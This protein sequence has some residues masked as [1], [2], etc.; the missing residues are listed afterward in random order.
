MWNHRNTSFAEWFVSNGGPIINNQ[1]MLA[2]GVV[3]FY[4]DDSFWHKSFKQGGGTGG[5]TETSGNFANDTGMTFQEVVQF[6]AAYEANM[7]RLYDNIVEQGGYVW[8]LFQDGPGLPKSK[9]DSKGK[10][11]TADKCLNA[12]RTR[13][14]LA[15]GTSAQSG[16]LYSVHPSEPGRTYNDS[17]FNELATAEFLLTRGNW[18]FMG[19]DWNGCSS[20]V[21]YYPRM[22]QWDED[23]GSPLDPHCVEVATSGVFTREW[24]KASV[25]WDC[26]AANGTI[27]R[28]AY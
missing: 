28:H 21:S 11:V 3:S 9:T 19:T 10:P 23:F 12:L 27:K 25:S 24:S 22:A 13:W 18:G 5:V 6:A 20:S 7:E 1:T 8:Q 16:V 17:T 2:P 15:N 14:C 4:I 26:H